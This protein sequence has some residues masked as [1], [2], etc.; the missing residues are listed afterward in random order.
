[1]GTTSACA[2]NT[3]KWVIRACAKRNYLRV[4]GE[5]SATLPTDFPNWELPPRARRIQQLAEE[6]G[7]MIGTTSACAENTHLHPCRCAAMGNYLRVR[8]EYE[9]VFRADFFAAEL[10]PR[11]RRIPFGP[12]FC[13]GCTGTT[14]ACAEN[15]MLTI[16]S[17]ISSGNYLRVR[18]EYRRGGLCL[19]V[20]VE[21]PPR[22]RRILPHVWCR[23]RHGGTT[24]ACAENTCFWLTSF[25]GEWNYLRVR[26][27][28]LAPLW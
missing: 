6:M 8:G 26:G 20:W 1:M 2:E 14:S 28:Y 21:L 11:A 25:G 9:A 3:K 19:G 23:G 17:T 4:R 13:K 5:Y 24:S 7:V 27:E 12:G 16:S 18:G 22:A 10:P 15:T